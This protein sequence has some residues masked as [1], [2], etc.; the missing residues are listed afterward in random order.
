MTRH[1]D[2]LYPVFLVICI[3]AVLKFISV[4]YVVP[5]IWFGVYGNS[6]DKSKKIS[7]CP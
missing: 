3:V 7:T 2:G 5:K 4:F 1:E 6:S